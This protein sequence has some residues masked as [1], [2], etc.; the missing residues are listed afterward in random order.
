MRLLRSASVVLGVL[1]V[2]GG[3]VAAC[4]AKHDAAPGEILLAIDANLNVPSDMDQLGVSVMA[5]DGT[6]ASIDQVYPMAPI[7]FAK[8]PATLAIVRGTA[9][10]I[11]IKVAGFKG[12]EAF[13]LRETVTTLPEG[14]TA[15]LRID[16][17]WL[18]TGSTSGSGTQV[19]A[20]TTSM[21]CV[22]GQTSVD[23]SCQAFTLDSATLPTYTNGALVSTSDTDASAQCLDIP[24]CVVGQP[25]ATRPP[26][27]AQPMLGGVTGI[28]GGTQ[29]TCVIAPPTTF[30][31]DFNIGM[32]PKSA[33]A[34]WCNGAG[35]ALPLDNPVAPSWP[36]ASDGM[37]HLP[38]GVCT[39]TKI[40]G[41]LLSPVTEGCPQYGATLHP[42]CQEYGMDGGATTIGE[43]GVRRAGEGGT[44]GPNLTITENGSD[45]SFPTVI[46]TV[47]DPSSGS[48]AGDVAYTFRESSDGGTELAAEKFTSSPLNR[49]SFTPHPVAFDTHSATFAATSDRVAAASLYGVDVFFLDD[50]TD[51]GHYPVSSPDP[52]VSVGF[53]QNGLLLAAGFNSGVSWFLPDGG[54]GTNPTFTDG[55]PT[56][57]VFNAEASPPSF[58]VLSTAAV[59]GQSDELR[60]LNF[61]Q[62]GPALTALPAPFVVAPGN[63]ISA[64][65]VADANTVVW[66]AIDGTFH[67]APIDADGGAGTSLGFTMPVFLDVGAGVPALTGGGGRIA[68]I[69]AALQH[70][71]SMRV[72]NGAAQGAPTDLSTRENNGQGWFASATTV[73]L[74]PAANLL[75]WTQ[76]DT[77]DA[78]GTL[79]SELPQ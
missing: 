60:S 29:P 2:A 66:V 17:N 38:I 77:G 27:P 46:G 22:A 19:Q 35:C 13:V 20:L 45:P 69:D 47:V 59:T 49:V 78:Y 11:D 32:I 15:I 10:P 75:H 28:D 79:L 70:V 26:E 14:R 43:G 39:S 7:G 50:G 53:D 57:V 18:D 51:A 4:S 36:V 56:Q 52:L 1:L 3:S 12:G 48:D 23:G 40:A 5:E 65:A 55:L 6:V 62:Q 8:F 25:G 21:P 76:S 63:S 68:W 67:V 30:T 54:T 24:D 64:F 71:W 41:L 61:E 33:A 73:A 44:G 31:G 34:G 72:A 37:V 42:A 74:A 16:L 58:V 9:G